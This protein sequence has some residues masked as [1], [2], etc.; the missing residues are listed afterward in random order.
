MNNVVS[1]RG[2][3]IA[4]NFVHTNS[5]IDFTAYERPLWYECKTGDKFNNTGHKA[6]VR[7]MNDKPVCLNVVKDTY[8]VVQNAELFEAI[9]EGLRSG[10][11]DF[12]GSRS[13]IIDRISYNGRECFR[14]YRFRGIGIESPDNDLIAFRVIVQNGFGS[15]AIKLY[16]GA[17]DFFCTNGMIIGDHVRT[18]AK[19]TSG[20]QINKFKE[21]VE[22]SVNMFWKNRHFYGELAGRKVLDDDDVAAFY[23][24]HFGDRL[25]AR[26]LR[27]YLIEKRARGPSLWS[28]Y[29][30]LTY[31]SSHAEGEFTLRNTSNDHAAS[32][33]MKREVDVMRV[34]K[35]E[36]FMRIAA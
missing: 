27:Q 3:T 9:D 15:R 28:V 24:K 19:H 1:L 32:T 13:E 23:N 18:Y 34:V 30:A 14:E 29:S 16:S 11:G 22:A 6:L 21:A 4:K 10:L 5:P 7:M 17:I 20:V 8:K 12:S 33:M 2:S 25:G 31:Y 35:D 26:L 36:D